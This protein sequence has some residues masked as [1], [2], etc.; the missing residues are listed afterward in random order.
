MSDTPEHLGGHLNVTNLDKPLL[1]HIVNTKGVQSVLDIGCG[2]GGMV[3]YAQELDLISLGID[4]DQNVERPADCHFLIHDFT[5]PMEGPVMV[6]F[7]QFDLAWCIEF[8]EHVDEQFIPHFMTAFK[9]CKYA[10]VTAAPPGTPGHHHVNCQPKEY[11]IE[12][13][14]E[15]GFAYD[16][17]YT[18]ELKDVSVMR[19]DFFK[20]NGM[21]FVR[22]N[23]E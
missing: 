12:K 15:Y 16:E 10:V 3:E 18:E 7:P 20:K 22:M 21:F 9:Y 19:K 14:K 5:Y 8:L 4:G 13:F 2:P 11:W 1:R 23:N 17:E 6:N